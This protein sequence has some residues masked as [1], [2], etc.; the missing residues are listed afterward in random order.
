MHKPT[1][2]KKK[3]RQAT[4]LKPG[5]EV[6]AYDETDHEMPLM[7]EDVTGASMSEEEMIEEADTAQ[8]QYQGEDDSFE[9]AEGT[10]RYKFLHDYVTYKI[11]DGQTVVNENGIEVPRAG[12][13]SEESGIYYL[14]HPLTIEEKRDKYEAYN[15]RKN[16]RPRRDYIYTRVNAKIAP[17]TTNSIEHYI[18]THAHTELALLY[19]HTNPRSRN[20]TTRIPIGQPKAETPEERTRR[21]DEAIRTKTL[22]IE[23]VDT[24]IQLRNYFAHHIKYQDF[25]TRKVAHILFAIK[26][27]NCDALSSTGNA[28]I[29][30]ILASGVSGTGKTALV[31]LIRTLFH[32]EEGGANR[33]CYASLCFG[34]YSNSSHRG[35]IN[36]IGVGFDG[37]RELC[38]VDHLVRAHSVIEQ[39]NNT[40]TSHPNIILVFI[41]ELCK[42]NSE[43][44]V[45][46]SLN[47]LF[48]KGILERA[49]GNVK[50]V[51]PSNTRLLF[52][53]TANYGESAIL[54]QPT[55]NSRHAISSVITD[56]EKKNVRKCDIGRIGRIVPFFALNYKEAHDIMRFV[57]DCYFSVPRSIQMQGTSRGLF[58]DYY[59]RGENY[60]PGCGIRIQ[61]K[62]LLQEIDHLQSLRTYVTNDPHTMIIVRFDIIPYSEY[63]EC[64][65]DGQP[66]TMTDLCQTYEELA[67]AVSREDVD[68]EN[69]QECL[70]TKA[71]IGFATMIHK[72]KT[73]LV[74]ISLPESSVNDDDAA[75]ESH[76][77][78]MDDD[79]WLEK[80]QQIRELVSR[81]EYRDL[82]LIAELYDI[83]G[84]I[85]PPV[86]QTIALVSPK[87]PAPITVQ[88]TEAEPPPPKKRRR[89]VEM[90][91]LVAQ[92]EHGEKVCPGCNKSRSHESFNK[93]WYDKKNI[94]RITMTKHCSTCR[95]GGLK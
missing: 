10:P 46:D 40:D 87:R 94:R 38:L 75:A 22:R 48:D 3:V 36:G 16:K 77:F 28:N 74:Y 72:D 23:D 80:E 88:H 70:N 12:V 29:I 20:N 52:Y 32:M 57:V 15:R 64:R 67:F 60:T 93:T 85:P 78:G 9:D 54:A 27:G 11:C 86:I 68:V 50:F 76:L 2:K 30:S 26:S 45:L 82:P 44:G 13:T 73:A 66:P 7:E 4:L 25:A 24:E 49:S 81:P 37:M 89:H 39:R 61:V 69:L 42:P 56:M 8:P 33:D 14:T 58:V 79:I 35:A 41:D 55:R 34:N 95:K 83:I 91:T 47:S 65:G 63:K 71:D 59:F 31:E 51:L 18:R 1:K 53:S 90:E 6:I 19:H 5:E 62:N 43:V 17:F 92:N 21:I 84:G